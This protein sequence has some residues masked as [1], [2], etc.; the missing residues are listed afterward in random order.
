VECFCSVRDRLNQPRVKDTIV[1][2]SLQKL[3]SVKGNKRGR[4]PCLCVSLGIKFPWWHVHT[5]NKGFAISC[6]QPGCQLP[7][8]P[9]AGNN[10]PNPSPWKVWSKK[11]RN[12]VIFLSCIHNKFP[13]DKVSIWRWDPHSRVQSLFYSP[14]QWLQ[15]AASSAWT[16]SDSFL[17][18][19]SLIEIRKLSSQQQKCWGFPVTGVKNS[20]SQKNQVLRLLGWMQF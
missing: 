3:L 10:L 16:R 1:M 19:T 15:P 9:W 12:L 2:A 17:S 11:S 6:P 5:V 8:S 20:N 13:S 4:M 18:W 7:N 14:P